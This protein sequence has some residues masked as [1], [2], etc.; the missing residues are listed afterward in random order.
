[1][2]KA[3]ASLE[4]LTLQAHCKKIVDETES[5]FGQYSV[6]DKTKRLDQLCDIL[7]RCIQFKQ[8]LE[9]QED[10]YILWCSHPKMPF[11]NERMYS[12]TEKM[13]PEEWVELS[14]WP[15]LHKVNSIGEWSVIEKEIVTTSS[16]SISL[17]DHSGEMELQ[18]GEEVF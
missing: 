4:S 7:W 14:L 8:K 15:C 17:V 5:L 18:Q 9:C 16:L 10:T 11:R 12:L 13:D 6:S 1:M 2:S 3:T